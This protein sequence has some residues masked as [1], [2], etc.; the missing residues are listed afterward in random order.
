M[1][2]ISGN[3]QRAIAHYISAGLIHAD[4]RAERARS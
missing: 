4:E 2:F 1:A 3:A